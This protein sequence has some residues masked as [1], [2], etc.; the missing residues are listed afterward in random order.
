M[1]GDVIS[2]ASGF[3][4]G[5]VVVRL[6]RVVFTYD[7][8][9]LFWL[10]AIPGLAGG[11]LRI[12]HTFLVPLFGTRLV[13]TVA[14]LLK[15]IPCVGIGLAVMNPATPFWVFLLLAFSAGFGGGG[16]LSFIP[17]T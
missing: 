16:F 8:M 10:A 2:F 3:E 12:V 13:I 15:L 7:T 6:P 4:M 9:Q 1:V 11:T 5:A 14:T 17:S